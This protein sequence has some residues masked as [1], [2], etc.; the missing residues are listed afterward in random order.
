MIQP[1]FCLL[2]QVLP[3]WQCAVDQCQKNV[4]IYKTMVDKYEEQ[5]NQGNPDL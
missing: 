3:K 4:D 1:Y 2:S 5:K